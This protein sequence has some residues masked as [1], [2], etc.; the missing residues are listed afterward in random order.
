MPVWQYFVQKHGFSNHP[1]KVIIDTDVN[2]CALYEFQASKLSNSVN[3]SL[4]YITVG[5]GVGVG[6]VINSKCVHGTLH[7][8]GG[9]VFVPK[10]PR[11]A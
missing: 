6:L 7:P 11:D 2:V 1:E 8:E 5:T 4:C 3:E 9:H 10:D